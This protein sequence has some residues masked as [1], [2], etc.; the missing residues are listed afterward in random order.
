MAKKK[1]LYQRWGKR[2]FDL[3]VSVPALIV[4]SPLMAV[5][6]V[7]VRIG[8]GSPVIFR[9]KRPGLNEKPLLLFTI[10]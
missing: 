8:L 7:F 6:A 4:L 2:F 10:N 9:Q 5:I 3:V 1:S